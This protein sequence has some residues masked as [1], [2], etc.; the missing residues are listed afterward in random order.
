MKSAIKT[1][2]SVMPRSKVYEIFEHD[3]GGNFYFTLSRGKP[4]NEI[5]KL[6]FTHIGEILGHF[7]VTQVV[8]NIGQLPKLRSLSN[9]ESE[10]QIKPD[11]WVAI[12]GGPFHRLP[13]PRLYYPSHRGFHYFALDSWSKSIESKV[14]I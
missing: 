11:R 6:F 10:W 12:C 1:W 9:I 8:Q 3:W 5:N 4:A 14:Q 7:D 13:P 2:P